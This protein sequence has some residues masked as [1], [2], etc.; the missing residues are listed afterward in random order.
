LRTVVDEDLVFIAFNYDGRINTPRDAIF[1]YCL[2]CDA[3]TPSGAAPEFTG[4]FFRAGVPLAEILP[5]DLAA[6]WANLSTTIIP[7]PPVYMRPGF[8]H[9]V[10]VGGPIPGDPTPILRNNTFI[11]AGP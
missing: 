6:V 11:N 4:V 5:A 10:R 9:W 7:K 1:L 8:F 2:N 3:R